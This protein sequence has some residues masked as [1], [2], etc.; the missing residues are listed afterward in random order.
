MDGWM[1]GWMDGL[2]RYDEM[3]PGRSVLN[4]ER[5][6]RSDDDVIIIIATANTDGC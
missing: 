4:F 3:R 5:V 1:N 6:R 2:M